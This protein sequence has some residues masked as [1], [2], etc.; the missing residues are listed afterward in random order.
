MPEKK[1]ARGKRGVFPFPGGMP[2]RMLEQVNNEGVAPN[3]E[4]EKKESCPGL[5]L[6]T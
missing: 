5:L 1:G 2:I 4:G 3:Y 6:N